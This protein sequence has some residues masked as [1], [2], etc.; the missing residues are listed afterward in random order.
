MIGN[1]V[2]NAALHGDGGIWL[3]SSHDDRMAVLFGLRRR[4]GNPRAGLGE[5]F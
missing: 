1:L 4:E 2:D 3:T 5:S